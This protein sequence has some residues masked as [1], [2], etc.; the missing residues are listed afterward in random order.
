MMLRTAL[1]LSFVVLFG[2]SERSQT[3][4]PVV[5]EHVDAATAEDADAQTRRLM[6]DTMDDRHWLIRAVAALRLETWQH[7]D[8]LALLQQL[9]SDSDWRVRSFAVRALARRADGQPLLANLND[10]SPHVMRTALLYGITVDVKRLRQHIARQLSESNLDDV[11]LGVELAALSADATLHER[12]QT[13]LAELIPRLDDNELLVLS[14]RLGAACGLAAEATRADWQLWIDDDSASIVVKPRT[15][16]PSWTTVDNDAAVDDAQ[17][18]TRASIA[19][20]DDTRF[21]A[22]RDDYLRSLRRQSIDLVI[23]IDRSTSMTQ[24]INAVKTSTSLLINFMDNASASARVGVVTYAGHPS[25]LTALPL[26]NRPAQVQQFVRSIG[27]GHGSIETV[28]LALTTALDTNTFR[29][30]A[31]KVVILIGDEPYQKRNRTELQALLERALDEEIVVCT[32]KAGSEERRNVAEGA[33]FLPEFEEIARSGG[34]RCADLF[35]PSDV[36]RLILALAIG[37][38]WPQQ[39]GD[40]LAVY[41]ECVP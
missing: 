9:A 29:K 2:L 5:A 26:S 31:L 36:A 17:P 40:L 34:G 25:E 27:L 22:F 20:L 4:A 15:H 6:V 13:I 14:D 7:A 16:A 32:V 3:D 37:G 11:L 33:T 19:A 23:C 12:A 39:L 38:S 41:S 18:E 1:L 30:N 8:A 28:T 21:I 35:E 24:T 10:R